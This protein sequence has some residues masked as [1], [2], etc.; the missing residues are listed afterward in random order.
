MSVG[1]AV[2]AAQGGPTARPAR[3]FWST[4]LRR[5][6]RD[7]LSLAALVALVQ[8][9]LNLPS[10]FVLIILSVLFTPS[11]LMLAVIFGL[12]FWPATTRQVRGQVLSLKG[13]D[14]V[15]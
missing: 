1:A 5:F 13:R 14:Y 4:A 9:V 2:A 10:L 6:A 8:F 12:F 3:G 11:V 15:D 7:R